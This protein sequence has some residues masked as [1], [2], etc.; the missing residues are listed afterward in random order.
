MMATMAGNEAQPTETV[1][2][3]AA[4]PQ[5]AESPPQATPGA[6]PGGTPTPAGTAPLAAGGDG[7][8]PQ[9]IPLKTAAVEETKPT[10]LV[11]H[12]MQKHQREERRAANLDSRR[13]GNEAGEVVGQVD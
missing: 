6:P 9:R 13:E 3:P 12:E 8:L 4:P 10:F 1:A 2:P 7:R 5:A 11:R